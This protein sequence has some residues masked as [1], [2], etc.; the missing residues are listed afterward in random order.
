MENSKICNT[1]KIYLPFINFSKASDNVS[2]GLRPSCKDYEKKKRLS[3]PKVCYEPIK[4]G[5][6]NCCICELDK[7]L[8]NFYKSKYSKT[9]YDYACVQCRE[10]GR[11]DVLNQLKLENP[12]EYNERIRKLKNKKRVYVPEKRKEYI[13]KKISEDPD[14]FSSRMKLYREKNRGKI[15]NYKK[16]YNKIKNKTDILV[17]IARTLRDKVRVTIKKTKATKFAHTKELVGCSF[18]E[19]KLHIEKQFTEGMSWEEFN[20][21]RI[22]IDHFLPCCSFNLV[23][24]EEQ[25]KCF[26]YTNLR[27]LWAEDNL[28]KATEDK[29]LSIYSTLIKTTEAEESLAP[30]V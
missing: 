21:G 7:S 25:R 17:R 28:R 26:H 6:L 9:G 1:C 5:P 23:D 30:I 22:H 8:E 4:I 10:Q 3:K 19:L 16:E 18:E 20:S 24:E 27:P 13:R 12:Q 14:Y 11:K 15:K 2:Y 29:K